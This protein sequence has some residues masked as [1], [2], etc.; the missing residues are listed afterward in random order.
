MTSARAKAIEGGLPL[1]LIRNEGQWLR[2]YL[3]GVLEQYQTFYQV[4]SA[5]DLA[6]VAVSSLRRA[7]GI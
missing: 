1:Q 3:R 5:A 7:A 4:V 2:R 6:V